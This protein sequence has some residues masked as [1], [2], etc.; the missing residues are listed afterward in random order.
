MND[1]KLPHDGR[2]RNEQTQRHGETQQR[3]W[4]FQSSD[5][6]IGNIIK[7]GKFTRICKATLNKNGKSQT[8][9]A[10]ILKGS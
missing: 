6:A 9:A 2:Q 1:E 8:V 10:K 3:N 4:Q 5:V 7:V